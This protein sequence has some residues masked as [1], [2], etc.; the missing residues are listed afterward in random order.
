MDQAC[1][2]HAGAWLHGRARRRDGAISRAMRNR[3]GPT[4]V[5][6]LPIGADAPCWFMAAQHTNPDEVVRIMTDLEVRRAIGIHWASF[7]QTDEERDEPVTLLSRALGEWGLE[8][9]R[10]AAANLGHI[11]HFGGS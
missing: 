1:P 5:A 9:Q 3:Y 10:F 8:T 4:Y 2:E 6:L 11:Y 7:Q